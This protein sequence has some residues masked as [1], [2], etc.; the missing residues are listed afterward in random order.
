MIL[1]ILY[2]FLFAVAAGMG[3][4]AAWSDL[5]GMTIPNLYSAV[6]AGLFPL[7]YG[8]AWLAGVDVFAAPGDHLLAFVIVFGISAGLFALNVMGAADSKL[9]SAFSLWV[10]LHGLAPFLFYMALTGGLLGVATIVLKR[11]KPFPKAGP[12]SWIGQAQAGADKVPYGVSIVAGAF[13]SFVL[14]GYLDGA[15]LSA[16]LGGS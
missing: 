9:A 5:R 8:A 2:I 11:L 6:V 12:Q 3:V 14:L 13:V 1:L 4:L 7:C 16:F 15:V 10:G